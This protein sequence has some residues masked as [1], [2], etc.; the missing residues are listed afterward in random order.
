L[1]SLDTDGWKA[2]VPQ[3][4]EH[5]AQFGDKLPSKLAASLA[6]LESALA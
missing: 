4:R 2:A 5:Y 1:L 6:E 3:I